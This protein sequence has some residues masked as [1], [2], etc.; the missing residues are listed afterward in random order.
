M[1]LNRQFLENCCCYCYFYCCCH[2]HQYTV[3]TKRYVIFCIY[4]IFESR[5]LNV[6]QLNVVVVCLFIISF[7]S[8]STDE[9]SWRIHTVFKTHTRKTKP[10][11]AVGLK[12]CT[13]GIYISD[14][15]ATAKPT[16]KTEK[17]KVD[18]YLSAAVVV[19]ELAVVPFFIH[20]RCLLIS[21]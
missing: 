11:Q 6:I 16:P 1:E 19:V 17:R 14:L 15:M 4:F 13:I 21:L 9:V 12:S 10:Q 20:S 2:H 8:I 7:L 18:V 5:F 3:H